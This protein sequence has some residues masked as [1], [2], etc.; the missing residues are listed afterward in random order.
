M[1]GDG[2]TS[3]SSDVGGG[4]GGGLEVVASARRVCYRC[5]WGAREEKAAFIAFRLNR[6]GGTFRVGNLI[7]SA[8]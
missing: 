8:S 3:L 7:D 4:V 2:K 1:L 6:V 5:R